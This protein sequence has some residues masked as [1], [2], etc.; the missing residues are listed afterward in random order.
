MYRIRW[1]RTKLGNYRYEILNF[2]DAV[3]RRSGYFEKKEDCLY[4]ARFFIET[5]L[6]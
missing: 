3:V 2:D 4:H 1:W 5:F 6:T